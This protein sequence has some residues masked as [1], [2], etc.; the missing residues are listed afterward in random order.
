MFYIKLSDILLSVKN[1][2]LLFLTTQFLALQMQ[3]QQCSCTDKL[4]M[5]KEKVEENYAGFADKVNDR[6][7]IAYNTFSNAYMEEA[8]KAK[9]AE[10]CHLLINDWLD[11]FRDG[12]IQVAYDIA[13]DSASVSKRLKNTEIIT[14]SDKEIA[15]LKIK[16]HGIEG[17]YRTIDSAYTIAIVNRKDSY[18]DY[19]GVILHSQTEQWKPGQVKMELI[20]VDSSRYKAIYYMRDHS[21]RIQQLWFDG[22]FLSGGW[23]RLGYR[24]PAEN[25]TDETV[26]IRRLDDS[27]LYLKIGSFDPHYGR[28]VDSVINAHEAI[29]K[30]IPYLVVDVRGNGGGSDF[31]Y[32]PVCRWLYSG[33]V[34]H[35]GVDVLASQDNIDGWRKAVLEDPEIPND[36]KKNTRQLIK[37]MKLNLG[38]FVSSSEDGVSE[39]GKVEHTPR[40]I[41]VLIDEECASSTEQFLLEARQSRKV[42]LMG[43]HTAGVLDYSNVRPVT[44]I[45]CKDLMLFVATTRSR[46]VD[47]GQGIDNVG[48]QPN[49]VLAR[50]KDWIR[51]AL[52]YLQSDRQ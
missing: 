26:Q 12:H 13:E 15:K 7:R 31:V 24:Q 1:I 28:I 23:T 34:Q 45:P 46:R 16:T 17:L 3:A 25:T 21:H 51:E 5:V 20:A 37:D 6:T 36:A 2:C 52:K 9:R 11:Y 50:D 39:R 19:V 30:T 38:K 4:R 29:L 18:R 32:Q 43:H 48:I 41:A 27:T 49:I 44:S 33:P 10:V 47:K 40:K 22:N 8:A 35:I 14:L 42:T